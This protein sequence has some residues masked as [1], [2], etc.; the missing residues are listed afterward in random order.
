[1]NTKNSKIP[2][3]RQ[4]RNSKYYLTPTDPCSKTLCSVISVCI[5]YF[6]VLLGA[7]Y[8]YLYTLEI[9]QNLDKGIIIDTILF[10]LGLFISILTLGVCFL[11]CTICFFVCEISYKKILY[12][13]ETE[14][15][16][17]EIKKLTRQPN[18]KPKK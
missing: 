1:M 6:T 12:E 2:T 15:I 4:L 18:I 3:L 11:F 14:R 9:N 17:N 13:K 10:G 5:I 16:S 8:I 7:V